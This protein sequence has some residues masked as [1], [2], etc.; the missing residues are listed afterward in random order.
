M[1]MK[2]L[3]TKA[4]RGVPGMHESVTEAAKNGFSSSGKNALN[5]DVLEPVATNSKR[6]RCFGISGGRDV[7]YH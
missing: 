1:R 6:A 4:G 5:V 7:N 2:G 3:R